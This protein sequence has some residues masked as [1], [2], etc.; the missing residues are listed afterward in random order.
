VTSV[1]RF[2]AIGPVV[3]LHAPRALT[4]LLR[5]ALAD[6]AVD[7]APD[8]RVDIRRDVLGRWSVRTDGRTEAL[9]G[10]SPDLGFYEA[11]GSISDIAARSAAGSDVVLHASCAEV[12]GTAV[13][14]AG[15]SGAGKSTLA[16]AL[17]L[18]GHGFL[19][20]EVTALRPDGVVRPF[21]RPIGL[22]AD[23]AAALG[24]DV[25]AGPFEYTYP[26]R[27]G[28]RATLSA[29]AAL[30]AVVLVQR[31]DESLSV[32]LLD[33][34]RALFQLANMTLGTTGHE[35]PMFARL[36]ALVRA[37]P[38]Y[39]LHYGDVAD[40]VRLVEGLVADLVGRGM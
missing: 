34:A 32:E 11:I 19:A 20:D 18:A 5:D 28:G 25:P 7:R 26:L 12:G 8:V 21:H 39:E 33:P 30:G 1:G 29:G 9:L 2:S 14:M 17:T 27:V 3:E 6:L 24:L 16:A 37:V 15:A 13:A 10:G 36:D 23:G 22:R 4:P 40:G 38:T 35:R 31:R